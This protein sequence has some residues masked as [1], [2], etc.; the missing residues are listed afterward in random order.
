MNPCRKVRDVIEY[1]PVWL[2]LELVPRLSRRA[3]LILADVLGA[4]CY[5]FCSRLRMVAWA[6]LNAAYGD[7]LAPIQKR[8]VARDSFRTC[9]RALLDTF[10]FSRDTAGRLA[11]YVR[12]ADSFAARMESGPGIVV[13]AHF[14]NWDLLGMLL[15][16]HVPG[17]SHVVAEIE[18]PLVNGLLTRIRSGTGQTVVFQ[19]GAVRKL[20][21]ALRAGGSTGLVIDQNTK[22]ERGGLFVEFFGLPAGMSGAAGA[23]ARRLDVPLSPLFC[24]YEGEGRYLAY[25]AAGL[26]DVSASD[27]LEDVTQRIA[28][29]IEA[30]IRLRPGQWLWMYKRWK[31]IAPDTERRRYPFYARVPG[32]DPPAW[33]GWWRWRGMVDGA[34]R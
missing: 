19:E 34:M 2:A 12:V 27:S 1:V 6:N 24:V 16:T 32:E 17:I 8:R 33:P 22:P 25:A 13:T 4:L 15:G 21:K 5:T 18:N 14:G 23:L 28:C 10:W 7:T 9:A 26:D 11:A 20:F 31:Y 30:E 29:L 3:V